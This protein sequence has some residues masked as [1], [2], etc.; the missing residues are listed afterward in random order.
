[1][2][3]RSTIHALIWI[4]VPALAGACGSTTE[5]SLEDGITAESPVTLKVTN[6]NWQD[7]NIYLVA[8]ATQRR[9]GTVVTGNTE[10]FDLSKV[11]PTTLT[12]V[13]VVIDPIGPPERYSTGRITVAPGQQLDLRVSQY[14]PQT[15]FSITAG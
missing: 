2:H 1:M 3:L 7:V 9:L 14:I 6:D 10:V 8:G 15:S 12:D 13:E 5:Q 11:A 4:C